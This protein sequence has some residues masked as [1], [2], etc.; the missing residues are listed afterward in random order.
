[1]FILPEGQTMAQ[2]K[3]AMDAAEAQLA[4]TSRAGA[5]TVVA[6]ISAEVSH[7]AMG[8]NELLCT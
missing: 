5:T 1:M 8:I 7:R 6:N 4:K 2:I 3:V